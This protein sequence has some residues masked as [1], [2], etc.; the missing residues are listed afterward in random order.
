LN[1]IKEV[2]NFTAADAVEES[3][4]KEI[5][6][7]LQIKKLW[8]HRDTMP[9]HITASAYIF[10]LG[11]QHLLLH[12]HRKLNRWLQLGGHCE[13][14]EA[15]HQCALRESREESGLQNLELISNSF[16]DLDIHT[17]PSRGAMP[18]HLHLDIRYLI[19]ANR[20]EPLQMDQ[21]ESL[22]LRWIELAQA[23]DYLNDSAAQRVLLKLFKISGEVNSTY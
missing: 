8:W 20:A 18:E 19:K 17:I 11:F 14:N 7:H 3:Y 12:H 21:R 2:E 16:F 4:R 5:L 13:A 23:N 6:Q 10:D 1:L 15:P 9:G 22:S